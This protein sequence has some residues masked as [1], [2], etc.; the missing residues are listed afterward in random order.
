MFS[1][2]IR[3]CIQ[4]WWPDNAYMKILKIFIFEVKNSTSTKKF[5]GIEL[6]PR[7][8]NKMAGSSYDILPVAKMIWNLSCVQ[9]EKRPDLWL[10]IPFFHCCAC[11]GQDGIFPLPQL[12]AEG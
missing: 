4:F 6:E 3:F 9:P 12:R 1:F 10:K 7:P 5:Q 8:Q 2:S 11:I